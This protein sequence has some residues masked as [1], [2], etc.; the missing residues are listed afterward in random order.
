MLQCGCWGEPTQLCLR[1]L[2]DPGGSDAAG[3]FSLVNLDSLYNTGNVGAADPR[4]LDPRRLR[5]RA[6]ARHLPLGAFG[7]LQLRATSGAPSTSASGT[8][9]L[10]PVYRSITE[11]WLP[12]GVRRRRLGGLRPHLVHRLAGA[13]D[14]SRVLHAGHLEGAR[15]RDRNGA[16]PRGPGDLAGRMTVR[17][18][19]GGD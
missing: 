19:R 18:M 6:A 14:D 16:R 3:A 8:E 1:N 12:G 2:H 7:R 9:L 5:R 13:R 4:R 10:F 11:G 15:R 17:P